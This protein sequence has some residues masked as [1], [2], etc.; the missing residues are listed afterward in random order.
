MVS[1][2]ANGDSVIDQTL[3]GHT[4]AELM[5]VLPTEA[6]GAVSAVAMIVCVDDGERSYYRTRCST[7]VHHEKI[8]MFSIALDLTRGFLG[9]D[10]E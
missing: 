6:D 2:A 7:N 3:V 5:D 9:E 1:R 4:A 10:D 8:G